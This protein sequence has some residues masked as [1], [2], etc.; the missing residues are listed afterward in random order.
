[1]ARSHAVRGEYGKTGALHDGIRTKKKAAGGGLSGRRKPMQ[2][3]LP[4]FFDRSVAESDS[5]WRRL[6]CCSKR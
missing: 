2:D 1:L 4:L 6:R 3:A 5:R